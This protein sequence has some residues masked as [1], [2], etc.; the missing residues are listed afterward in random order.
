MKRI[1][2][3][4]IVF[5]AL[6]GAAPQSDRE[7]VLQADEAY[8]VA[9]LNRDQRALDRLLAPDFKGV[10]QGGVVRDKAGILD[11]W[12]WFSVDS[13]T[14]DSADVRLA[15][16]TATVIGSMTENGTDKLLFTRVYVKR[17]G[18]WQLLSSMQSV[19][20]KQPAMPAP[21]HVTKT[22]RLSPAEEDVM[23]V[24]EAYR[25]AKLKQDTGALNRLLADGFN[26]TNQN[27]N[28]RNK[29]QTLELWKSFSIESLNT[30]TAEVRIT[31]DTAVVMGTQTENESEHMLFNRVYIR[32]G[33]SWQLLSSMQFRNAPNN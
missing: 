29:A 32:S 28:S 8:R 2:S 18:A 31:G 24:D 17:S 3:G 19:D 11:L 12:T 7:A 13:L 6:I 15:G 20:P 10:N 22:P 23:R 33:Y 9:K 30:D 4:L 16:D 1:F 14:T 25:V 5:T 21:R 26:E 27:G